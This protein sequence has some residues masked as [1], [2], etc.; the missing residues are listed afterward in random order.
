MLPNNTRMFHQ[1]F[2]RPKQDEGY[3]KDLE[4]EEDTIETQLR[5][6]DENNRRFLQRQQSERM[7]RREFRNNSSSAQ[8]PLP[9]GLV[10]LHRHQSHY[11]SNVDLFQQNDASFN[12]LKYARSS[13]IRTNP[14]S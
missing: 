14:S 13:D 6:S 3:E 10:A 9:G 1:N 12:Y 8:T 5:S 2:Y 11:F 4:D 7:T